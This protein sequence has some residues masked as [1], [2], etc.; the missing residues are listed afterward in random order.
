MTGILT[1]VPFA[2]FYES[3]HSHNIDRAENSIVQDDSGDPMF[4]LFEHAEIRYGEVRLAYVQSYV[5]SFG[6]EFD[7]ALE[8]ESTSSPREYNF[9]TDRVF[10]HISTKDLARLYKE[11]R[12]S[13][14]LDRYASERFTSR[15][16][17]SSFYSPDWKTWGPLRNWDHNQ[18][19]TILDAYVCSDGDTF[20]EWE[21]YESMESADGNGC[22]E[23]WIWDSMDKK[24]ARRMDKVISYLRERRKRL[25][26]TTEQQRTANLPFAETPLGCL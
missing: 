9:E 1:T 14:A 7:V 11:T 24:D 16:G 26:R 8:F 22:V 6:A 19:G 17:F 5:D 13:G 25:W 18:I 20:R 3:W 23:N 2:G 12:R 10:A 21:M 4:C 15:S